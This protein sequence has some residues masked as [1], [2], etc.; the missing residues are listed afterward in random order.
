MWPAYG[1]GIIDAESR[2]AAV[3]LVDVQPA[4]YA[5]AFMLHEA[6]LHWR[7]GA[8]DLGRAQVHLEAVDGAS[9]TDPQSAD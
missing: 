3:D 5:H 7:P 6:G 8:T 4:R 2:R 9:A 1:G